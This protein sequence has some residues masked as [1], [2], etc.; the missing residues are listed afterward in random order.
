VPFYLFIAMGAQFSGVDVIQ[1]V[2]GLWAFTAGVSLLCM[3]A[4]SRLMSGH[5]AAVAAIVAM[6]TFHALFLSQPMSNLVTVFAP[7]P[8]RYA[9]AAGVLIPLALFHFLIHMGEKK[10]NVPAFV[11]LVYLI[12]E[13]TFIHARETLFFIGIVLVCASIMLFDLKRNRQDL[14][15]IFWLLCIVGVILLVYRQ[16]NL[17]MQPDLDGFIARLRKDMVGHLLHGWEQYGIGSTFGLPQFYGADIPDSFAYSDRF[18]LWS[19]FEGLG[20]VPIVI[21]LLPVYALSV[22]R[23]AMLLAPGRGAIHFRYFFRA[24]S[25]CGNHIW[26]LGEDGGR[27]ICC[28]IY[29]LSGRCV[30]GERINHLGHAPVCCVQ[31]QRQYRICHRFA[32]S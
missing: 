4:I 29:N 20:F 2:P 10:I 19:I 7:F 14:V 23:P 11:G 31:V 16:M 28:A 5:W 27:F 26:R 32:V 24:L 9:L 1:A 18:S 22:E 17:A 12:T 13:I 3:V 8:D 25:V 6:T 15:R 21:C 30:P